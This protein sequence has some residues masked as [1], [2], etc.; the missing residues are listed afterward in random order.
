MSGLFAIRREV[1]V[2]ALPRLSNVG[3]KIL[4]D[5]LASVTRPLKVAEIP[6][7][8]Q[9]RVAGESK[10]DNRVVQEYLILLLEKLLGHFIPIRFLMFAFVGALGVAVHLTTLGLMLNVAQF[11]FRFSQGFAVL[12]AMTFNYVLN[13]SI[14]YRD[15]QLKGAAFFKGL[16]TFYAVCVVGAIGNIGVGEMVYD[17]NYTWWVA[18]VAGA[19]IGVVWNYA[20]SSIFTWRRK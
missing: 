16:I 5:V 18:G 4:L 8:F 17:M 12:T 11:D 14:T 7:H 19:V 9:D 6:Y 15:L 3:F 10:L 20:A 1:L 13:N 2:D